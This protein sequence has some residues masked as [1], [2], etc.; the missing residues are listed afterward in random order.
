M[1]KYRVGVIGF[2]QMHITTMV[3]SFLKMP[4][5]YEFMIKGSEE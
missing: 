5:T 3:D 4:E 2:G 1:K